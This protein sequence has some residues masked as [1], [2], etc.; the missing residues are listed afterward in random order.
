MRAEFRPLHFGNIPFEPDK[1]VSP[2]FS[3]LD[4]WELLTPEEQSIMRTYSKHL[5]KGTDIKTIIV[6]M[7]K[8]NE[9]HDK[10]PDF[11]LGCVP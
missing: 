2:L 10:Y 4:T 5:A 1:Y 3:W 6:L 9:I 7:L 8:V 11:H